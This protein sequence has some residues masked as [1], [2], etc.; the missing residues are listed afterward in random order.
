M[1]PARV[2]DNDGHLTEG[3]NG[4]NHADGEKSQASV[5]LQRLLQ[6]D[7]TLDAPNGK[8]VRVICPTC[9][10]IGTVAVDQFSIDAARE[11]QGDALVRLYIFAGDICEHE[12]TVI[13][14]AKFK[15]R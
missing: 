7:V 3:I 15:A 5:D 10:K 13:L 4:A 9:K 12:F 14:D 6:P 1:V 8:L 2:E 11:T